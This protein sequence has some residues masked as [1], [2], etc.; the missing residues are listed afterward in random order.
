MWYHDKI[1]IQWSSGSSSPCPFSPVCPTTRFCQVSSRKHKLAGSLL[2]GDFLGLLFL[3]VEEAASIG[4]AVAEDNQA[5]R[6]ESLDPSD[7]T[8]TTA[9][10]VLAIVGLEDILLALVELVVWVV[11]VTNR[12]IL[13]LFCLGLDSREF[14]VD[15]RQDTVTQLIGLVDIWTD[16]GV[17]SLEIWVG[18]RNQF[19]VNCI[20][21]VQ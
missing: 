8:I 10:L 15:L 12:G 6:D 5:A 2:L 13:D 20:G 21:K 14:G 19:C 1:P 18:W 16:I 4:E 3:L 11:G 17:W 9:L 7:D